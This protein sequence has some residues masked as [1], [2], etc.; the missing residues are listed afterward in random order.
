M[1]CGLVYQHLKLLFMREKRGGREREKKEEKEEEERR[2]REERRREEV[3]KGE[4]VGKRGK[5]G[6]S[7]D[8]EIR[9][10][11]KYISGEI[12]T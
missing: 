5:E 11:I 10:W 4:R 3:R 2:R 12:F 7:R 9:K 1:A 8:L 6:R